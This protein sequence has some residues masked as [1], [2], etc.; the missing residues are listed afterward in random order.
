MWSWHERVTTSIQKDAAIQYLYLLFPFW[1]LRKRRPTGNPTQRCLFYLPLG[2]ITEGSLRDLQVALFGDKVSD[3]IYKEISQNV[4]RFC[5][6]SSCFERCLPLASWQLHIHLATFPSWDSPGS[7]MSHPKMVL[8]CSVWNGS[9]IRHDFWTAG[10]SQVISVL[11]PSWFYSWPEPYS[12]SPFGSL[13]QNDDRREI[14]ADSRFV[15]RPRLALP[16]ASFPTSCGGEPK[17]RVAEPAA[18]WVRAGGI[19]LVEAWGLPS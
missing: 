19:I 5:R 10:V 1:G 16:R 12:S 14:A 9:E 3:D 13:H 11:S 17:I 4:S 18:S 6:C 2:D 8:R 15:L 7:Q